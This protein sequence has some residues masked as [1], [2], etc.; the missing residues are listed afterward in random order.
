MPNVYIELL[1][2][3][4]LTPNFWISEEYFEKAGFRTLKEENDNSITVWDGNQLVFPAIDIN[5]EFLQGTNPIWSDFESYYDKWKE[6]KFLD[7]NYIYD[8]KNF[9][10]LKGHE[11]AVFRKNIK[12][13][14]KRLNHSWSYLTGVHKDLSTEPV[15]EEWLRGIKS[16]HDEE[17]LLKYLESGENKAILFDSAD[18]VYGINIWDENYKFIN[19]RYA[20]CGKQDFV[21]EFLRYL[22]Y[23]NRKILNS[24]KLV[25]DGGVLDSPE[26]ERFK[27]KLNPVDIIKVYSWI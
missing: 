13:F 12:K 5:G 27:N 4:N 11:W 14:P 6:P 10:N 15:V 23:T 19:Y 24:G 20:I 2:K 9:L 7:Y 22:F 25:N 18:K 26:L 3:R 8:P 16:V 17:V 21:S 1:E